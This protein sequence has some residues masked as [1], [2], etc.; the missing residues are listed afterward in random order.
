MLARFS[1][2]DHPRHALSRVRE[3]RQVLANKHRILFSEHTDAMRSMTSVYQLLPRC[4][5]SRENGRYNALPRPKPGF[6]G[7]SARR[8]RRRCDSAAEIDD[9]VNARAERGYELVPIVG[10]W[11]PD[12]RVRPTTPRAVDG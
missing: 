4:E 11:R 1:G 7:S 9:A 8:R 3:N 5:I 6:R 2:P 10:S 12:P